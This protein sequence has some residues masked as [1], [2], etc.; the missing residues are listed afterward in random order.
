MVSLSCTIFFPRHQ[1][2]KVNS[3]ATDCI[4]SGVHMAALSA[5]IQLCLAGQSLNGDQ[6]YDAGEKLLLQVQARNLIS[7]NV[8]ID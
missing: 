3:F 2:N 7:Q 5:L 1:L 6:C 8:F 4:E